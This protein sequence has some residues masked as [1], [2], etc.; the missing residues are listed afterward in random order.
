MDLDVRAKKRLGR[1]TT[2]DPQTGLK[3]RP[4]RL[5]DYKYFYFQ[6]VRELDLRGLATNWIWSSRGLQRTPAK[7]AA[8]HGRAAS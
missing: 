7:P 4:S 5:R 1:W 6:R 3:S 8:L 2:T